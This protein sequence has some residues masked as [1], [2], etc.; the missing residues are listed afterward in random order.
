MMSPSEAAVELERICE[1]GESRD[2]SHFV[3]YYVED[4][5][6]D[7]HLAELDEFLS[8]VKPGMTLWATIAVLRS[9]YSA[10]HLL[11]NWEKFRDD[12]RV[13]HQDNPRIDHKLRGLDRVYEPSRYF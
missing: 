11:K 1:T 7:E 5:K 6:D 2:I 13:A 8:L 3:V 12:V 9:T 10:S 4:L